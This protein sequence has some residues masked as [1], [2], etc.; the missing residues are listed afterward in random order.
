MNTQSLQCVLYNKS[1]QSKPL[2]KSKDYSDL[3][4][5]G[6]LGSFLH[7]QT[8]SPKVPERAV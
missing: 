5:T 1:N 7:I 4:S 3:S 6:T 2:L 8:V